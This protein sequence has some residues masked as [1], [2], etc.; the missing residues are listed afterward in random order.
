MAVEVP[1]FTITL[2]AAA[3][4]SAH[5]F[6]FVKLDS[7]GKVAAISA[8]TDCPVGV[9]QNKPSADGMAAEVAVLGVTKVQGDADLA[10]GAMIYTSSDGQAL[11]TTPLTVASTNFICGQ[12]LRDNSTAGGL[13]TALINCVNPFYNS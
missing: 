4:L 7:N 1:L 13:A 11:S 8:I 2:E 9:L 10:R 3:D 5:Q 12:V 6:K